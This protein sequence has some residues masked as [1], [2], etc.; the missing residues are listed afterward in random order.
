MTNSQDIS[1]LSLQSLRFRCN[2]ETEH[3]FRRQE[4]D[5]RY[6][7]EIFRRAI[8]NR[9]E[10]SWECIYEQYQPLI[11]KWLS[12]HPLFS[13]SDEEIQYFINRVFDK[14]WSSLSPEKFPNFPNLKSI[15]KYM[16]MCSHSV[17]VDHMRKNQDTLPLEEVGLTPKQTEESQSIEQEVDSKL[18]GGE[19]WR[20]IEESLKDEAERRV[21]Y[22]S[23]I[24]G[25]KPDE[26]FR[27][28]KKEFNSIEA[29]YRTKEKV[30]SRLRRNRA[31]KEFFTNV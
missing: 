26:L 24:L 5:P 30:I 21:I 29:V 9:D 25:Q 13:S 15:L 1:K 28:H 23:F 16:Q 7:F 10:S 11:T 4:Y 31:L 27:T 12:L 22:G 2:Q 14:I 19:L 6:C 17:L 8:V 20:I 18:M 3:F